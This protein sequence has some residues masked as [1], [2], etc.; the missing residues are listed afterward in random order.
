MN[1]GYAYRAVL[2]CTHS[3]AL[4]AQYPIHAG[5]DGMKITATYKYKKQN[6]Q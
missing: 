4:Y 6:G 1:T 3:A 2:W 5:A